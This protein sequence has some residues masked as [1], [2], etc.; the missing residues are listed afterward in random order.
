MLKLIRSSRS[1]MFF[2]LGVLENFTT[3]NFIKKRLWH[4][5][6]PVNLAKL[7]KTPFLQNTSG[8]LLLT[9]AEKLI[10]AYI[11]FRIGSSAP[12]QMFDRV[13]KTSHIRLT[14]SS[15]S[16]VSE[17]FLYRPHLHQWHWQ[18]IKKNKLL[19]A[20]ADYSLQIKLQLL[21][22]KTAEIVECARKYVE[23]ISENLKSLNPY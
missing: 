23:G 16:S 1:Q 15:S 9:Y 13:L 17:T 14:K 11:K 6:F 5:C 12:S 8:L 22:I 21:P 2:K 19:S 3:Y 4:T 18:N 10:T 7:L 20:N